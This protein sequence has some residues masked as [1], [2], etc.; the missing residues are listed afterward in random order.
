MKKILS[1][2]AVCSITISALAFEG[3]ISVHY[4]GNAEQK[5]NYNLTWYFSGDKYRLDVLYV[6]SESNGKASVFLPNGGNKVVI[7]NTN[8]STELDYKYFNATVDK[9]PTVEEYKVVATEETR[10][11]AGF[12]CKK[13]IFKS[14]TGKTVES[15]ITQSI[16]IDWAE[17]SA[18]LRM[19]PEARIMAKYEIKGF[20][21]STIIRDESG[22]VAQSTLISIK[23]RPQAPELFAIPEGYTE[24]EQ[25]K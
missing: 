17:I 24:M 4:I 8:P 13:Y 15:W 22:T 1:F 23:Q 25:Q 7:Y 14:F 6:G 18:P 2:I 9:I 21:L 16:D 10:T 5:E 3:E 11:I 19:L 12:V 20:P